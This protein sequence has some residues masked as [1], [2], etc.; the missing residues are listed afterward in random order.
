MT[1]YD[2]LKETLYFFYQNHRNFRK[3]KFFHKF[4]DL[5]LKKCTLKR[6]VIEPNKAL[7]LKAQ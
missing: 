6:L 7:T 4:R 3:K 5:G 2:Q 1:K